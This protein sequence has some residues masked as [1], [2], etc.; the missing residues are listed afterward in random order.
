MDESLHVSQQLGHIFWPFSEGEPAGG[1]GSDITLLRKVSLRRTPQP[2]AAPFRTARPCR[3]RVL[4]STTLS[5]N[6]K[7]PRGAFVFLVEPAGIEPASA[8]LPKTVLHT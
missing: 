2:L 1:S 4:Y 7:S 6:T 3:P 5:K 8:S